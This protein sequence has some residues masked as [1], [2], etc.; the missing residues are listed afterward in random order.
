M[1]SL[2]LDSVYSIRVGHWLGMDCSCWVFGKQTHRVSDRFI[3]V[4][5]QFKASE[6]IQSTPQNKI[7]P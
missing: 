2:K 3:E 1:Q 6:R 7:G 5:V 4:H